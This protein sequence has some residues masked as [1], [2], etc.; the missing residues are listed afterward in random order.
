MQQKKKC[1]TSSVIWKA[2]FE[3]TDG[4]V[5][6]KSSQD[7]LAGGEKLW[8]GSPDRVTGERHSERLQAV[9]QLLFRDARSQLVNIFLGWECELVLAVSESTL[10]DRTWGEPITTLASHIQNWKKRKSRRT[11]FKDVHVFL[12]IFI[13]K[14]TCFPS[15]KDLFFFF[16]DI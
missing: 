9:E 7:Q 10:K 12:F 11:P 16:N 15:F 13:Y 2:F 14:T 4:T 3:S 8:S 1:W 6:S 5:C